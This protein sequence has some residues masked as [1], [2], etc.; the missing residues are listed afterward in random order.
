MEEEPIHYLIFNRKG[1]LHNFIKGIAWAKLYESK[2]HRS[3]S[4]H[5]FLSQ[6]LPAGLTPLKMH[7]SP[8]QDPFPQFSF[9][10]F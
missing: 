9:S 8:L 3:K 2:K 7:P 5:E 1:L 6:D 10:A 4:P